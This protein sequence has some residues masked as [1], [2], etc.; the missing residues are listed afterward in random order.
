MQTHGSYEEIIVFLVL[1]VFFVALT[2]SLTEILLKAGPLEPIRALIARKFR[3][4]ADLLSCGYCFS[5]WVAF[6]IAWMIPS[7]LNIAISFGITD[8]HVAFVEDYL[9]WFV[10]GLI[11]H[12]LA[13]VFH[14]KVTNIPDIEVIGDAD[15]EET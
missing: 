13:N 1:W 4:F 6:S 8:N 14:N 12:R 9:W 11:L 10:N 3:F 5:V 15:D 2:E 7:P